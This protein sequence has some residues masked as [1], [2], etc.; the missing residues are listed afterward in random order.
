MAKTY[1]SLKTG[2]FLQDWS[3]TGLITANDDWSKV[4]SIVGY[5][6]NDM[7]GSSTGVNPGTVTGDST[8]VDVIANLTNPNT[9]TNGGVGEFQIANPTIALQ[10]SGTAGAPYIALYMDSTGRECRPDLQRP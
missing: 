5:L 3:D 1:F 10:G 7:V 8:D 4:P 2:N 6:G 9:S